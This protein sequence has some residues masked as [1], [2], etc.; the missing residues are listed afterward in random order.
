MP[1]LRSIEIPYQDP[2]LAFAPF[3]QD[4]YSLLFDSAQID[5]R[6]G[7]FSFIAADPFQTL[8]S[9]D[10]K[11]RLG[12]QIFQ[13]NPFDVLSEQLAQFS[14]E[15]LPGLPPFQT[16]VAG[17]FAY[18][19]CHHLERLPA[20]RLDDMRFPDLMLGFYD[21]VIA[22]D[23]LER[24]AW[25]LS[26]GYP[27]ATASGR[28]RR[29]T[30]RAQE[31][32]A[33]LAASHTQLQIPNAPELTPA[34]TS[35]FTRSR[36]E[37]AVRQV[38][39]YILAGDVFQVN[40]SQ[41]F[42]ADLSPGDTSFALYQRL[43]AA[44]PA[45]F[46]AFLNYG[47]VAIASASPERFMFLQDGRLETR[48]IK[49]TRP[50]SLDE[51][52]D[53]ALA[54]ELRQ[55][56]KDSAEN[57]MIVDLMRNDLSRI[58]RPHTVRVPE[59]CVLESYATVHHLVS[60]ITGELNPGTTAVDVLKA[61]LPGGSITGAPKIR[62]MEII[63]EL[64]PGRRGPYCGNI[65][66]IGFDGGMDLSIAIRTFAVRGDRVTFQVGGGIVADSDPGAEYEETLDKARALC[67]A[68]SGSVAFA[69]LAGFP[70]DFGY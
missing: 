17:Y 53:Q 37:D 26:S 11:V 63:A 12:K 32:L 16:G 24:S 51:I 3:S 8:S 2:L 57:V 36:Y 43:R 31:F 48:P 38:I 14:T 34:I 56:A 60:T 20:P 29:A 25:L 22:F 18:D 49:G 10:G 69:E 1:A 35:D 58:C 23:H 19:L 68:L 6:L 21:V 47:E 65:G 46:A 15:S 52:K 44:N 54:E 30:D 41:R 55:S 64:E 27:E 45:P 13:T 59:L 70:H 9:K 39:D 62:A 33:R 4:P 67:L 42:Q 28:S 66:Y 7:R 50:R 5:S 40:L 61:S